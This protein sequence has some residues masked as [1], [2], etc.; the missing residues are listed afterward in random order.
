[1]LG[2]TKVTIDEAREQLE[3][4]L[5]QFKDGVTIVVV[6]PTDIQYFCDFIVTG[7]GKR[8]N[9]PRKIFFELNFDLSSEKSSSPHSAFYDAISIHKDWLEKSKTNEG[10]R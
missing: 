7:P 9:L 8:L 4:Y 10:E 6:F 5:S 3:T 1:M 2:Q